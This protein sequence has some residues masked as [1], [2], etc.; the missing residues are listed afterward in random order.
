MHIKKCINN[1]PMV[2]HRSM[3]AVTPFPRSWNLKALEAVRKKLLR[4]RLKELL[5]QLLVVHQK[6]GSRM[7]QV[8]QVIKAVRRSANTRNTHEYTH[9]IRTRVTC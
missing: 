9:K 8:V 2:S 3:N 5:Q 6:S 1:L 7:V 4:Q